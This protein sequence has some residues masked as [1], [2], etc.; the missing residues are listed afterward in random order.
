[1]VSIKNYPVCINYFWLKVGSMAKIEEKHFEG[2]KIKPNGNNQSVSPMA[3]IE[4]ATSVRL[5][6]FPKKL[7]VCVCVKLL[8]VEL[9]I[10]N[11]LVSITFILK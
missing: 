7:C 10:P 8:K 1:M 11:V 3:Q 6:F 9:I 5:S 2:Q 4:K